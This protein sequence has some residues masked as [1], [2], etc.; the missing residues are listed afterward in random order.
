MRRLLFT[1]LLAGL[2]PSVHCVMTFI[3]PPP[4]SGAVGDYSLN[5]IYVEGSTVD[6]TWTP[7]T[8]GKPT[9]ISLWQ[10]DDNGNF[11][12]DQEYITH[13]VINMTDFTWIVITTKN[14]TLS[15]VF[16]LSIFEEGNTTGDSNSHY[17]NI[18]TGVTGQT[19]PTSSAVSSTSTS[20][21]SMT[22]STPASLTTSPSTSTT[23]PSTSTPSPDPSNGGLSVGAQ[24]GL[25]VAIPL[26]VITGAVA[27]WLFFRRRRQHS[28]VGPNEMPATP[29]MQQNYPSPGWGGGVA[30]VQQNGPAEMGPNT[31]HPGYAQGPGT[32]NKMYQQYYD[33]PPAEMSADGNSPNSYY[34]LHA[35]PPHPGH[36]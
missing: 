7:G 30:P 13:N 21:S 12:G 9:S 1:L 14:L 33:P 17:F 32:D 11:F 2:A 28:A 16:F 4:F 36:Q 6:V 15:P 31:P 18:T 20:T 24:V 29:G 25:G 8:P 22:S 34:E 5:P 27:A 23:S 10:L 19:S 26:A 3:S 35:G